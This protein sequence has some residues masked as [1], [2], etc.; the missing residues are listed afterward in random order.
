MVVELTA[1]LVGASS[2]HQSFTLHEL[3]IVCVAIYSI[4]RFTNQLYFPSSKELELARTSRPDPEE[5]RTPSP[6]PPPRFATPDPAGHWLLNSVLQ[7]VLERK[8]IPFIIRADRDQT[9]KDYEGKPARTVPINKRTVTPR[10]DEIVVRT[11]R[12]NRPIQISIKPGNLYPWDP[13]A[14]CEVIVT[15]GSALGTVGKVKEQRGCDW[16]VTFAVD[17]DARDLVFA[18]T[19]LAVLEDLKQ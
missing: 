5:R 16:V 7:S 19:E 17:D 14:G 1:L 4:R 9:L 3:M 13:L 12:R 8:C 6:G 10:E 15:G 18:K 11:T 2:P